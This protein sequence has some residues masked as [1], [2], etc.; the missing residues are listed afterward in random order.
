[1]QSSVARPVLARLLADLGL[2]ARI[3]ERAPAADAAVPLSSALPV[4]TL[5][6]DSVDAAALLA[7]HVV[8]ERTGVR[9]R[10]ETDGRRTA[11]AY[12]SERTLLVDGEVPAVWAPLSGF[13]STREGWVRT[14]GNYPHHARALR[15][16]LE[17]SPE[18]TREEVRERIARTDAVA[19]VERVVR[20]GGVAA[21]AAQV[22]PLEEERRASA[23]LIERRSWRAQPRKW[24][25]DSTLPLAGI[26]VLDLT[27]VIAGPVSTRT[28]AHFGADV[29]RI[30]SPVLPELPW[31]HLDTGAGKR[32]ALLDLAAAAD[33][34]TFHRLLASADVVVL[35]YRPSGL[36]GLGLDPDALADSHPGLVIARLSAWGFEQADADRRGFDSIVQAA[37]GIAWRE[38]S[39]GQTPGALPAQ[40]LDHSAGYLLAAAVISALAR[41]RAEGGTHLVQTSLRR[42]AAELLTLPAEQRAAADPDLSDQAVTYETDAGTVRVVRPAARLAGMPDTFADAPHAWGTD[43]PAWLPR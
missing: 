14:H 5:A 24:I 20:L 8:E 37:S 26:R 42:I 39:D 19:L 32:S 30:D 25:G 3:A 21:V 43:A 13:W 27:R 36:G 1:M 17:V 15:I 12:S 16:A 33:R 22:D 28:L 23:P 11:A 38:S 9:V 4:P 40:A 41:Q 7:A 29:L 10:P 31:Q 34:A 2:D 18:A 35:G 6:R